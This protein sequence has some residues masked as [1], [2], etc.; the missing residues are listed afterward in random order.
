[1][2]KNP[3]VDYQEEHFSEDMPQGEDFSLGEKKRKNNRKT[4]LIFGFLLFLGVGTLIFGFLSLSNNIHGP[5]QKYNANEDV[6]ETQIEAW[7]KIVEM[8]NRDTD[9]DELSDYDEE[10]IYGTSPY[11]AD[12]D[13]DG[14]TD[15]QEIDNEHDPLCPMGVNC[16]GSD[17]Q[18]QEIPEG[19]LVS[20]EP[21]VG[22][23]ELTPEIVDQ[24]KQFTPDDVRA[25]LVE[26]GAMTQEDLN[27]INDEE[28]MLMFEELLQTK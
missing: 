9:E 8:Q 2:I 14:F 15:K 28:L 26:S 27:Q 17:I 12:T 13:S 16:S 3:H 25:L 11:L 24:L 7:E 6:E 5:F 22:D 18:D 21:G 20:E 1:M 23:A 10:Y 4:N 19:D